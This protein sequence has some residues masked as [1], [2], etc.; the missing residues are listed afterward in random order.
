MR[1]SRP[2]HRHGRHVRST[3]I[4]R[5]MGGLTEA[6]CKK[7]ARGPA[8]QASS[9]RCAQPGFLQIPAPS[10]TLPRT[11]PPTRG[12]RPAYHEARRGLLSCA[13]SPGRRR[14]RGSGSPGWL[15]GHSPGSGGKL[16]SAPFI[17]AARGVHQHF[18]PHFPFWPRASRIAVRPTLP[19]RRLPLVRRCAAPA[20]EVRVPRGRR[21][22]K[23]RA[24]YP[25]ASVAKQ[26]AVL[27]TMKT[28]LRPSSCTHEGVSSEALCPASVDNK[29]GPI[30]GRTLESSLTRNVG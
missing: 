20:L 19:F 28:P 22:S 14:L 11:L 13:A 17:T 18:A 6:R 8:A 23:R 16:S 30:P 4:S 10:Q 1:R 12:R 21:R 3:P 24:W 15:Q 29:V 27:G 5:L 2:N 26:G 9:L 25:S 7:L